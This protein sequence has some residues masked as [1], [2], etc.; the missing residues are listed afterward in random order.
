[1]PY[2]RVHCKPLSI[3]RDTEMEQYTIRNV[4]RL[5][6]AAG[7][8]QNA[9]DVVFIQDDT[10]NAFV[11][12]GTTVFIHTGL[13][14]NVDNSDEF[15]GVLAH[16]TGH[17]V[18]GHS[19]RLYDNMQR[20]QRTAL[21]TTI[22]GGIAAVASGRGDVGVAIMAGGMGTAQNFFSSY[23]IS[24][25]NAADSTGIRLIRKIGYSPAGLL[26][27][28]RK[29]QAN[30][31]LIID[32]RYA[33][34]Q[35]HPLTQDRIQFLQNAAQTDIPL[36]DDKEFHLIKA[37]LFAFLNEPQ[38]TL[39]TYKGNDEAA[40]YAKAIAYFKSTRIQEALKVTDELIEKEP[41]NPYFWELKGQILFETGQVKT[42]IKA[43]QKAVDKMPEAPLIR[44]SL[45]HAL[46][47]DNHPD[48]AVQ[49]LEYIVARDA[50]LPDAWSF[51]GR[52]YGMQGKKGE[53]LYAMAEYDYSTGQYPDA[54][55]KIKKA[56]PLL[57]QDA[58]KT[59]RLQDL[60]ESITRNKLK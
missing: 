9:A 16:E 10:L 6:K 24:E 34:T 39:Q 5:F 12:G 50:Y 23:R 27:V 32:P 13:I 41:N 51:L 4:K 30:E 57:K 2:S 20:A 15:F 21:V 1:M 47:E 46:L 38:Q 31:R 28:M 35:T 19:V 8:N 3:I 55:A 52:G 45:A 11:A 37:K 60:E 26:S 43:Y 17:I 18:G 40:L 44:L 49:H 22:L 36:T 33:Y 42:A 48:E 56:L 7:L 58:V 14:T 54:L 59:L 29:I 25:E 53:A